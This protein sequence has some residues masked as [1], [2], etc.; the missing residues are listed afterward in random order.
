MPRKRVRNGTHTKEKIVELYWNTFMNYEGK[1]YEDRTFDALGW[2]MEKTDVKCQVNFTVE[3]KGLCD[4]IGESSYLVKFR[5]RSAFKIELAHALL[6]YEQAASLYNKQA[7]ETYKIRTL[8]TYGPKKSESGDVSDIGDS[9]SESECE[10]D[11]V[12]EFWEEKCE[13]CGTIKGSNYP[14]EVTKCRNLD[15]SIVDNLIHKMRQRIQK[16]YENFKE[17]DKKHNK[18]EFNSMIEMFITFMEKFIKWSK[19]CFSHQLPLKYLFRDLTRTKYLKNYTYEQATT[20]NYIIQEFIN[21][22]V[23]ARLPKTI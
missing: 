5:S 20:V 14:F 21:R 6:L 4:Y 3:H 19:F 10:S 23:M 18:A 12:E 2:I 7:N 1:K 17:G 16:T 22:M 11:D 15:K 13:I 9:E 8:S